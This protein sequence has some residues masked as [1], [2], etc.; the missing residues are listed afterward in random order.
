MVR[1]VLRGMLC[2]WGGGRCSVWRAEAVCV[3]G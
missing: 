3:E 2:G 1:R